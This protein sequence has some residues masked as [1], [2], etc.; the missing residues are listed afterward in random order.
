MGSCSAYTTMHTWLQLLTCMQAYQT[1]LTAAVTAKLAALCTQAEQYRSRLHTQ[2]TI[3]LGLLHSYLAVQVDLLKWKAVN[4]VVG[5]LLFYWTLDR[6]QLLGRQG[7]QITPYLENKDSNIEKNLAVVEISCCTSILNFWKVEIS[8]CTSILKFTCLLCSGCQDQWNNRMT[9]THTLNNNNNYYHMPMGLCPRGIIIKECIMLL[10]TDTQDEW[11]LLT[12]AAAVWDTC[13]L[14][15]LV[16]DRA[17]TCIYYERN[18]KRYCM[19]GYTLQVEI[20]AIFKLY[21]PLPHVETKA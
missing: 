7:E 15:Q 9:D 2:K 20:K 6:Q 10:T 21:S 17:C 16:Y 11:L 13:H 4:F 3:S 12:C 8:C 19:G 14:H 1:R 18:N 5:I